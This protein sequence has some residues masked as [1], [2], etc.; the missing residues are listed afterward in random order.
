MQ[1][2]FKRRKKK[3]VKFSDSIQDVVK[4]FNFKNSYNKNKNKNEK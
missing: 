3:I 4:I 1:V 2:K